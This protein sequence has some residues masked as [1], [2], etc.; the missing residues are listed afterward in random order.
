MTFQQI[1]LKTPKLV[2]PKDLTLQSKRSGVAYAGQHNVKCSE[3][4]GKRNKYT[5][6][7][8][9]QGGASSSGQDS[10]V[11]LHHRDKGHSRKVICTSWREKIDSLRKKVKEVRSNKL[12]EKTS[13]QMSLDFTYPTSLEPVLFSRCGCTTSHTL[14][15]WPKALPILFLLVNNSQATMT[16]MTHSMDGW[17][18]D[19]CDPF[20]MI[21][22]NMICEPETP[23]I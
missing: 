8:A 7:T 13:K 16:Q 12:K 6:D 17:V 21:V 15:L 18:S 14:K 11:H 22:S 9:Q 3:L 5:N 20:S 4:W 23:N 10:A 19:S 1:S 2:Y